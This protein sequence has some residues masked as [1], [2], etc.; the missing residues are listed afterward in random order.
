M[1]S[2]DEDMWKRQKDRLEEEQKQRYERNKYLQ[3]QA[4]AQ[5][6]SGGAMNGIADPYYTMRGAY[7]AAQGMGQG[8]FSSTVPKPVVFNKLLWRGEP[9]PEDWQGALYTRKVRSMEGRHWRVVFSSPWSHE[10]IEV[11][12]D[13]DQYSG[14]EVDKLTETFLEVINQRRLG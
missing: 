4:M 12:F 9:L 6:V 14:Q 8:P 7:G 13:S 3:L 1:S 10:N 2:F 5:N 11:Y